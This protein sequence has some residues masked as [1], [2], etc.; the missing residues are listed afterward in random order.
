MPTSTSL[1]ANQKG[2]VHVVLLIVAIGIIGFLALASFSS[3]REKLAAVLNRKGPSHASIE[4]FEQQLSSVR[5][6]TYY[7]EARNSPGQIKEDLQRDINQIKSAGFNT[8]LLVPGWARYNPKPMANPPVYDTQAF[9]DL[10]SI[11]A[12]LKANGMK[13]ILPLDYMEGGS[14]TDPDNI[15]YS[16]TTNPGAKCD[17]IS[18]GNK[19]NAFVNYV[20]EVMRQT[21]DYS[22]SV[23]LM[24]FSENTDC[25]IPGYDA[26]GLT[27]D[28]KAEKNHQ[29]TQLLRATLGNL[30]TRLSPELR[31]R[32]KFGYYDAGLVRNMVLRGYTNDTP[33]ASPNPFDF[34]SVGGFYEEGT[35][36]DEQINNSVRGAIG[37][38]RQ[39][40]P[41]TPLFIFEFGEATCPQT[42][43]YRGISLETNQ[44]RVLEAQIK[45]LI[46][47]NLG[48][49]VWGW[50]D[51][52]YQG[53]CPILGVN[54]E[55]GQEIVNQ[56]YGLGLIDKNGNPKP[57]LAK[58]TSLIATDVDPIGADGGSSC[59]QLIGW[60]CDP[61]NFNED[62]QVHFYLDG[63]AYG[64]SL[65][66]YLTATTANK[67]VNTALGQ[68]C[69]GKTAKWY[70]LNTPQELR[71]GR[72]HTLYTYPINIPL[73]PGK[74]N[75]MV[76]GSPIRL[77]C[78]P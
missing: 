60:A 62:L 69:G 58:I 59:K 64:T 61:N 15:L 11:L 51:T 76:N 34:V 17:W 19:F 31:S 14:A 21:S 77:T 27:V 4:S 25:N 65:G 20:N 56:G 8:I 23:Y 74:M 72:T 71:D 39:A 16:N 33:V 24:V 75:T 38:F 12:L 6:V 66:T 48:F 50:K 5:S 68:Y 2:I 52:A 28:Q 53:N 36:T 54:P 3:L 10:K 55:T 63:P 22:D 7:N 67:E 78:N 43:R 47:L 26:P 35:H 40:F 49:N 37:E 57:A 9:N 13:A 44:S 70:V 30:P 18:N 41:T 45:T 42:P 73:N 1:G 29:L 46:S 32:F